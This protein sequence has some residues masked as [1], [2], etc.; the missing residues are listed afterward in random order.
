[1]KHSPRNIVFHELIG[2]YVKVLKHDDPSLI[3]VEGIIVDETKNTLKIRIDNKTKTILKKG[4]LLLFKLSDKVEVL[5]NGEQI[6][7]RPEERLKSIKW[8]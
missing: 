8:R 4:A 5:V 3:G 1:M 2:L 6:L 7:G